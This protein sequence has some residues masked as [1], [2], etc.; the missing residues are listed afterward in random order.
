MALGVHTVGLKDKIIV[1][2]YLHVY[3]THKFKLITVFILILTIQAVQIYI[4]HS[5]L[6]A[7]RIQITPPSHLSPH[8][9]V[10]I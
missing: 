4:L 10:L 6:P 1:V 5:L 8:G 3:L 9:T 7:R 2:I